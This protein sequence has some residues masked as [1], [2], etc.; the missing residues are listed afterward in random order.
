MLQVLAELISKN[1]RE[2]DFAGRYGGEEFIVVLP[3]VTI[4]K[5]YEIGERIR[6]TV[7]EYQ[8]SEKDLKITIS[9]GIAQRINEDAKELIGLADTLLYKAKTSGRNRT[10]ISSVDKRTE[11]E[12]RK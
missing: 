3:G 11:G 12:K 5:A 2:T 8:F 4:E 7:E 1:I 9:I 10:E 6:K